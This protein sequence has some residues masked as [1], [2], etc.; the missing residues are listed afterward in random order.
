MKKRPYTR[1]RYN[2]EVIRWTD[3]GILLAVLFAQCQLWQ[4]TLAWC[5]FARR[6]NIIANIW[7]FRCKSNA[8]S[9]TRH[10][11][12][13]LFIKHRVGQTLVRRDTRVLAI[14]YSVEKCYCSSF[15]LLLIV[16]CSNIIWIVFFDT[17]RH[18]LCLL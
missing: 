17:V 5:H 3:V 10:T 4:I 18:S 13:P 15:V 6:A 7:L 2:F 14:F 1:L 16:I 8:L 11:C 12:Q 9:P